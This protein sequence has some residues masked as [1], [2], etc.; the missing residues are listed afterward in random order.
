VAA[1]DHVGLGPHHQCDVAA[2]CGDVIAANIFQSAGNQCEEITRFGMRIDKA[3]PVASMLKFARAI[4]IA[5]GKKHGKAFAV[6]TQGHGVTRQHVRPIGKEGDVAK[7]FGLALREQEAG[8]ARAGQ[9]KAFERR[10]RRGLQAHARL[11]HAAVF[12][13]IHFQHA[14]FIAIAVGIQRAAVER[15]RQQLQAFAIQSQRQ[16]LFGIASKHEPCGD[17]G[18][19]DTQIDIEFNCID[20][21]WRA[22]VIAQADGGGGVSFGKGH[23]AQWAEQGRIRLTCGFSPAGTSG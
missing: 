4:G 5:A 19:V 6:G 3:R 18:G 17:F 16:G 1:I 12:R 20:R 14:V 9:I 7:P 13:A 21:P 2:V 8:F 10:V 15:N 22:A 23:T 11:Q